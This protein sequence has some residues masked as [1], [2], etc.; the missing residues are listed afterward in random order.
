MGLF[1]GKKSDE[2]EDPNRGAL[3]GSRGG[4]SSSSPANTNPYAQPAAA[5]DPYGVQDNNKYSGMGQPYAG[6]APGGRPPPGQSGI[7]I[8]GPGG[9]GGRG[10]LPGG[11]GGMRGGAGYGADRYAAPAS[12]GYG[13]A[14][15]YGAP[16]AAA[17]GYGSGG[18]YGAAPDRY[19][20]PAAAEPPAS[21]YGAG[22]Y[23]GL[24]RTT[25]YDTVDSNRDALFSGAK[26][27]VQAKPI[28]EDNPYGAATATSRTAGGSGAYGG[29]SGAGGYGEAAPGGY[30]AYGEERKLTAEEE[31]EEEVSAS[32]QQIRFMKQQDVSST[33]NALQIAA[34][35][36]Q[37]GRDT[38]ARLGAQGERIH[39]TERNLDL[40]NSHNRAATEKAK[41]LKTLNRSMFAM[42]VANPFTKE[43]RR[44]ARDEEVL[45]KHR[46]E[47]EEREATRAAAYGSQARQQQSFKEVNQ[48]GSVP[49]QNKASLAERA[50]YQFEADSEDEDMENEIDYN[51]DQLSGAAGRLNALARATGEEVDVQ[52]KH[53]EVITGKVS[54]LP[55]IRTL[56]RSARY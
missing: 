8:G 53:I 26:E 49:K 15:K 32:K 10:G 38:L 50:K 31:E 37:S 34:Q 18:G 3:F 24:G 27:R 36:E 39:N 40:A 56:F 1:K 12:G 22:G 29:D 23:G 7:G 5:A 33:R 21:R 43:T 45:E 41:E 48:A 4:K 47:K 14:D 42:H 46:T 6:G 44:K 13:A 35:A 19:A 9:P 16:P 30:G 52:N 51:L 28:G 54:F 55:L 2:G 11:P 17:G 25:S 20:S